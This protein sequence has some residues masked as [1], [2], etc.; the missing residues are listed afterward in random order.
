[1][2]IIDCTA[3]TFLA[4]GPTDREIQ[5]RT[6]PELISALAAHGIEHGKSKPKRYYIEQAVKVSEACTTKRD[7]LERKRLAERQ[8]IVD[9]DHT[10]G[11]LVNNA[12][13]NYLTC[14]SEANDEALASAKSHRERLASCQDVK[15]HLEPFIVAQELHERRRHLLKIMADAWSRKETGEEMLIRLQNHCDWVQNEIDRLDDCHGDIFKHAADTGVRNALRKHRAQHNR[16]IEIL[17]DEFEAAPRNGANHIQW[18]FC[19][20]AL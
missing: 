14:L 10:D 17:T 20:G 7:Q 8:L 2:T 6:K 15:W 18:A 16:V 9:R 3:N 12:I 4:G 5:Q 1:M 19:Y 13:R 11:T